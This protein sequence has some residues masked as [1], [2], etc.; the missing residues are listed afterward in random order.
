[1]N[2]E[3]RRLT[4][5]GRALAEETGKALKTLPFEAEKAIEEQLRADVQRAKKAVLTLSRGMIA[6]VMALHLLGTV[7]LGTVVFSAPFPYPVMYLVMGLLLWLVLA[8]RYTAW[9]ARRRFSATLLLVT[10]LGLNAFWLLVLVDDEP[11]ACAPAKAAPGAAR[12][13]AMPLR[14][15][16]SVSAYFGRS[17]RR[18]CRFIARSVLS[19]DVCFS[20]QRSAV[21]Y[22]AARAKARRACRGSGWRLRGWRRLLRR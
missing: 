17:S 9:A 18:A 10:N 22:A 14:S 7:V 4:Q 21:P 11:P 6:A 8:L 5:S 16:A 20:Q 15:A 3:R 13:R 19:N 1:M 2:P 12:D